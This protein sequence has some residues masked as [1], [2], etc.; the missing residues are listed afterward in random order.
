MMARRCGQI[1]IVSSLAGLIPLRDSPSYCASKSAVLAYGLSLRDLLGA[2][3]IGVSV[4]CPGYVTTP[5]SQKEICEKPFEMPADQAAGIILRGLAR[6][7]AIIAFPAWF[8]FLT[9]LGGLLPDWL[10]ERVTRGSRFNVG[11]PAD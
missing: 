7:K 8:A 2:S 9:R 4:I 1:A 6:N 5:M 3:G 10:R 11:A